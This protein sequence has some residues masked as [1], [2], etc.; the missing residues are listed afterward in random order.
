MSNQETQAKAKR[1]RSPSYPSI[2]LGAA[3]ERLVT[4][5]DYFKRHP[6][7]VSK[8]GLAW[9]MKHGSSQASSTV[10]ALKSY[11]LVDYQGSGADLKAILT[12]DGRTYL[13]AQQDD[14]KREILRRAALK[15]KAIAKYWNEWGAIRPP[16]PICLDELV[17]K[18]KFSKGGAETFL[19]VYDATIAYAG[20]S[21]YD[22]NNGK[23]D[24]NDDENSETNEVIIEQKGMGQKPTASPPTLP[25]SASEREWLRG[26]LSKETFYRLIVTG[27]LGPN[28]IGKLI[29]LLQAQKDVLSDDE[30]TTH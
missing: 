19:K 11:G 23:N 2:H 7:S 25:V 5:D 29:K 26:P 3:I 6:A 24:A 17:L 1:D 18:A 9:G 21:Q 4:L 10:A 22:K 20:L 13:R 15:P 28:E 16:D 30:E 14:I 8:L 12:D 27:N